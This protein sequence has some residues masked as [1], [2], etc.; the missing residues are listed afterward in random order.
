[1]PSL[2]GSAAVIFSVF[3]AKFPEGDTENP[4]IILTFA[5]KPNRMPTMELTTLMCPSAQREKN[6]SQHAADWYIFSLHGHQANNYARE[7]LANSYVGKE[8]SFA[9][10]I[11]SGHLR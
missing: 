1:M 11:N 10:N 6:L 9:T 3:S 2:T 4:K 5:D 7:I 8:I